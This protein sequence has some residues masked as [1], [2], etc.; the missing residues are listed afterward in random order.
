MAVERVNRNASERGN[1]TC[2]MPFRLNDCARRQPLAAHIAAHI[3][4][5]A[6][7]AHRDTDGGP[8]VT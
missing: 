2:E 7:E 5:H 8:K 3:A 6:R 1:E 4:G